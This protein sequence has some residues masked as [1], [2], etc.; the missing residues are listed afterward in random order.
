MLL[1]KYFTTNNYVP[2]YPK[3]CSIS[4]QYVRCGYL[5]LIDFVNSYPKENRKGLIMC[6]AV[7]PYSPLVLP[8]PNER[9]EDTLNTRIHCMYSH[10]QR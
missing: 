4:R 7:L 8:D 9:G 3:F 1:I 5:Y 10:A 6:E 2:I